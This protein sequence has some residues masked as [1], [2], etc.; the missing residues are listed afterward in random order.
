MPS[1]DFSVLLVGQSFINFLEIGRAGRGSAGPTGPRLVDDIDGLIGQASRCDIPLRHFDGGHDRVV[2]DLHT[3]MVFVP[4]T[5]LFKIS[6]VSSCDVGLTMISWNRRARALS[7]ST[8]LRYS[9]SIMAPMHWISP[10]ARSSLSTL[11]ASMAP[12]APPAPTNVCNSSINKMVFFTQADF[13]HHGLDA[14]FELTTVFCAGHHHGQVENDNPLVG[15]D[16]RYVAAYHALCEPFDD[17][18]FA[19]TRLAQQNGVILCVNGKAPEWLVRF[20]APA[21]SH[22]QASSDGPIR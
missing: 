21:R 9:S 17:R 2:G 22:D 11:A 10:R 15:Q 18:G 8:Y 14:L 6:T 19:D 7:F 20:P 4:F 16:F 3:V 1:L 13:V 12:S 5:D